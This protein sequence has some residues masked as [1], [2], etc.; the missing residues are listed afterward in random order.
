MQINTLEQAA[1]TWFDADKVKIQQRCMG[2]GYELYL[3]YDIPYRLDHIETLQELRMIKDRLSPPRTEQDMEYTMGA[4]P[5]R[6]T[7]RRRYV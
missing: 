2:A 1:T 7:R 5:K 6:P 4:K 3:C